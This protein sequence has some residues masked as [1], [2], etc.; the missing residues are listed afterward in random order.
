MIIGTTG[1]VVGEISEIWVHP[2]A[3]KIWLSHVRVDDTHDVVQIVFGGVRML[4]P[5]DLVPVAL[6]GARVLVEGREKP[7]KMRNR[8]YRGERSHGMLC[9]LRELGWVEACVDEVAVLC[10]LRPGQSLDEVPV[11]DRRGHVENWPEVPES[12]HSL[13]IHV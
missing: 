5:G 7:K 12:P 13:F 3:E 1:A 11:P 8:A 2:N 6:P 9:S 10:G 4:S